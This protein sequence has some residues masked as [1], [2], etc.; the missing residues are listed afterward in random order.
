MIKTKLGINGACGRM[1]KRIVQLAS[2]DPAL[3][4]AAALDFAAH[5]AQGADIG[6]AA[7]VG[8]L[9]VAVTP[10]LPLQARLDAMIDFSLPEGTMSVLKTCIDRKIPLVVATTGPRNAKARIE[11]AAHHTAL[12]DG[13][14]HEPG[15][16]RPLRSGPAGRARC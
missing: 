16:Q 10:A 5:P 15:C 6:T 9:G 3:Q 11:A 7:G 13:P 14:Q 12:L 1:G 4:I 8:P 2:E